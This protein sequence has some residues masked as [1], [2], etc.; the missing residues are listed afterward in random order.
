MPSAAAMTRSSG[1]VMKPRTSSALAPTYTVV[2]VMAAFSLRGYCRTLSERM[3]WRPPIRTTRLT[4]S[5]S[6]GRRMK[7]SVKRMR[8]IGALLVDRSGIQLDGWSQIIP[9]DDLHPRAQL[10]RAV[11]DYRLTLLE[12]R[13]DG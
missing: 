4:T 2:T 9:E 11:A 1:V 13:V 6:T 5:A 3:A 8:A 7:R 12:A 10:E